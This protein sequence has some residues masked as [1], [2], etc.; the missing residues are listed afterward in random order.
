MIAIAIVESCSGCSCCCC[1]VSVAFLGGIVSV[2][3]MFGIFLTWSPIILWAFGINYV[4]IA[5]MNVE[6]ICILQVAWIT[7]VGQFAFFYCG[8]R[9][10]CSCCCCGIP[11]AGLKVIA[12]VT[13]MLIE[14]VPASLML[15]K[16]SK[17]ANTTS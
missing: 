11:V 13:K 6:N 14:N 8:L 10:G 9:Y 1:G 2:V 17:K 12:M 4:V 15:I 7:A 3:G 16:G 5:V